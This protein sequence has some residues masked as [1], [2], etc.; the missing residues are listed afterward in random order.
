MKN[1]SMNMKQAMK[2]G[3]KMN[4]VKASMA[5]MNMGYSMN[6]SMKRLS[7]WR[8]SSTG[9]GSGADGVAGD[10]AV[11]GDASFTDDLG[12]SFGDDDKE[13]E[14]G[15][16]ATAGGVLETSTSGSSQG[17]SPSANTMHIKC[18]GCGTGFT[19][20]EGQHQTACPHCSKQNATPTQGSKGGNNGNKMAA[21]KSAM[22]VRATKGKM[23]ASLF[24]RNAAAGAASAVKKVKNRN[25]TAVPAEGDST[26]NDAADGER[27]PWDDDSEE[28]CGLDSSPSSG[29]AGVSDRASNAFANILKKSSS[30]SSTGHEAPDQTP[31]KDSFMSQSPN[32]NANVVGGNGD[33]S[34]GGDSS[35]VSS[36]GSG[37]NGSGGNG[38]GS[39]GSGGGLAMPSFLKRGV[40]ITL[41]G[42]KDKG[43]GEG[44]GDDVAEAEGG[45][46]EL[47]AKVSSQTKQGIMMETGRSDTEQGEDSKGGKGE[48]DR[49][50]DQGESEKKG[51]DASF[52]DEEQRRKR[53]ASFYGMAK[54]SHSATSGAS[55][56][57]DSDTS[58]GSS[59]ALASASAS[60]SPSSSPRNGGTINNDAIS[61]PDKSDVTLR[62]STAHLLNKVLGSGGVLPSG[63]GAGVIYEN[64]RYQPFRGWGSS[65]PGHLLPTDR[66]KWSTQNGMVGCKHLIPDDHDLELDM[67]LPGCDEDGWEYAFAF[68]QFS[69]HAMA[70]TRK[71]GG[72][73]YVRRRAYMLKMEF[74]DNVTAGTSKGEGQQQRGLGGVTVIKESE[75]GKLVQQ[76]CLAVNEVRFICRTPYAAHLSLLF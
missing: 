12:S 60:S 65:F 17:S 62:K 70:S 19:A 31:R 24:M 7:G 20:R 52:L 48:S 41:K 72:N 46:K 71:K 1:T 35:S 27:L 54:D 33:D 61:G 47:D 58:S 21:L 6:N 56:A 3:I 39:G 29:N 63:P 8:S 67:T 50:D 45:K 10:T 64:Q 43:A 49:K 22:S 66:A 69:E 9:G 73:C 11:D 34:D 30:S 44:A 18:T 16:P 4:S 5:N 57:P 28:D 40:S 14:H 38:S 74:K 59:T 25:G 23:G 51:G 37:G 53:M 32:A 13:E 2:G 75:D 15:A 76:Q 26:Q 36:S 55:D 42:K 68:E